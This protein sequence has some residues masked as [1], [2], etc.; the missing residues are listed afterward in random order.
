MWDFIFVCC[1]ITFMYLSASVLQSIVKDVN[2]R[3]PE[4]QKVE[5]V[6]SRMTN[7]S[8]MHWIWQEHVRL[9]P[10]SQKRN[11]FAV[12]LVLMFASVFAKPIS[13]LLR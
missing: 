4:N 6:W 9:Y 7:P 11:W 2:E 8:S 5:W 1:G 13:M 10:E 12:F 3:L